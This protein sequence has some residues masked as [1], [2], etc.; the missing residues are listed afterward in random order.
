MNVILEDGAFPPER[1][2]FKDAGLDFRTPIDFV[3][4]AH[5][6]AFVDT[7]VHIEVPH[8]TRG[9]VCSKSGLNKNHGLTA[10]GTIDEGYT[11]TVGITMHNSDDEDYHFKRGDKVAQVVFEL[12]VRPLISIIEKPADYDEVADGERGSDGYGST[13]K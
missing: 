4:P 10:D 8:A 11:G 5:G 6:Y 7:G 9:H 2:H 1:A 3:V 13:G 12:I